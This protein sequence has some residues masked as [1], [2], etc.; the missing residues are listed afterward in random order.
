MRLLA[1]WKSY[2]DGRLYIATAYGVNTI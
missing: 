2:A 1:V